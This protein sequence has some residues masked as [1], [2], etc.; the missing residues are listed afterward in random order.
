MK[1]GPILLVGALA[2]PFRVGCAGSAPASEQLPFHVGEAVGAVR[3]SFSALMNGTAGA[4]GSTLVAVIALPAHD[5][6]VG[7]APEMHY[8]QNIAP[9][10]VRET[11]GDSAA[12]FVTVS[13]EYAGAPRDAQLDFK[14]TCLWRLAGKDCLCF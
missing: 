14:E 4:A 5:E 3:Q 2:S 7:S 12:A 13:F 6:L 10:S 1:A 9:S 11:L 8:H